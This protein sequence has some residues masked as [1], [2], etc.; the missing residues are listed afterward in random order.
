[1]DVLSFG[2]TKNGCL[3]AEAVIFFN[4]AHARDVIFQR[5]RAGQG[6]S[7]GWFISA[8]LTAYLDSGHWLDLARHAN[9]MAS[10]LAG[11]LRQSPNARLAF[12]RGGNQVFAI[13]NKD[14]DKRLRA[15]GAAYHPSQADAVPAEWRPKAHETMVRL[16]TSWQTRAEDVDRFASI[17][18]T[19]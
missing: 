8:Q 1:V 17:V 4:P 11:A 19:A 16:V 12:E 9:A 13:L 7:K 6:F 15:A 14:A 3:A 5:Q 10:R 18:S 2:G